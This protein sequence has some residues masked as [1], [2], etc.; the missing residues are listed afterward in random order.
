MKKIRISFT[1]CGLGDFIYQN[2]DFTSDEFA[3]YKSVNSGDGGL[4]PGKLVFTEE[5]EAFTEA[6]LEK[7]LNDITKYNSYN[8]FSVGGPALVSC[9]CTAQLLS[10][11]SIEIKYFGALGNDQKA[12]VL[13]E[14]LNKLPVE[15]DNFTYFEAATP[16]TTV[17]SDP[18]FYAGKGERTFINNIGAA[19][20]FNAEHFNTDFW[21]SDIIVFGGTAL[22][23]QLHSELT[24]LLQAAKYKGAFT[25]V[26]TVF[27][28]PNE[29][30]NPNKPWPLGNTLKSLPLIDL[31]I[32][33]YEEAKRISGSENEK[34]IITF[35]KSN[36]TNAFIITKGSEPSYIYSSGKKFSVIETYLPVC[37]WISIDFDLRPELRGDTTGCGDNF[38]GATIAS[39]AKQMIENNEEISLID[40]A[41]WGTVAGGLSCY[42]LGGTYFEEYSGQKLQ[43]TNTMLDQYYKNK[44]VSDI[45]A[46]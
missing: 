38:A 36:G 45:Y 11:K 46:H 32:M 12:T 4:A 10:E 9:I 3:K 19:A 21:N 22:V 34:D 8:T 7:I 25:V 6:Q 18:N 17:L 33:D 24:D 29:K 41:I 15:T 37:D 39:I 26:N 14:L 1:G 44:S 28:F 35:F 43:L 23:P 5:L 20:Y 16:Y 2:V 31:L 42:Y 27:D 13:I 30:K 40:A